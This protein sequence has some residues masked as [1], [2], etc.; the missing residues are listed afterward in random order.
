MDCG[1]RFVGL[2]DA[3]AFAEAVLYAAHGGCRLP[4]RHCDWWG[5]GDRNIWSSGAPKEF[6]P[7]QRAEGLARP[8]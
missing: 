5:G 8:I 1:K 6:D 2:R 7:Q 4:L 3:N